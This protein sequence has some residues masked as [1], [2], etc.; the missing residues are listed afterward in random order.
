MKKN[1]VFFCI[2]LCAVAFCPLHAVSVLVTSE[3]TIKVS[4]VKEVFESSFPDEK[5]VIHPCAAPSL[6]S[7]QPFGISEGIKGACNRIDNLP[8]E[9]VDQ[10][11]YL[12]SIE[13]YIDKEGSWY[14]RAVIVIKSKECDEK[15][16]YFTCKVE[17]P[18]RFV[19]EAIQKGMTVGKI[20][21]A[22]IT[23]RKID[24]RDWH[25]EVEFGGVS[26]K[27]LIKETLFKALHKNEIQELR[28][29]I[30]IYPDFPKKGVEFQ[31]ISPI[32]KNPKAFT[33]C[34]DLLAKWAKNQD[35][36]VIVGLESRGF[37]IGAALSYKMGVAFVPVR[38]AGKIPGEVYEV[39]YKKEYGEDRFAIAKDSKLRG[40]RVLIVDDLIATGGSAKASIEL[41][42][43][44]DATAVQFVSLLE[45]KGLNGAKQ[46]SI[47]T[48]NLI[49]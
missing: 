24:P 18:E 32:L 29:L 12:V 49:D 44:L 37:I 45:V 1:F 40:Q 26:R 42:K 43:Q 30:S 5:V 23:D 15:E 3:N 28:N 20:I 10:F 38:K 13:N 48:F 11:D 31:D 25:K 4:A 47:P 8:N 39:S 34:I 19:E 17:V 21:Q 35:V 22:S 27:E 46:V 33:L 9:I 41:V 36:D 14:D 7:E 2:A 6:I 16:L